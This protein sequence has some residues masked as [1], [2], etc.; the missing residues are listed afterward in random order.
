MWDWLALE[1]FSYNKLRAFT[2]ADSYFLY[3][4]LAI[5]LFFWLRNALHGR[6]FQRLGLT[7]I[8][9]DTASSWF[10]WLR[11]LHPLAGFLALASLLI[12]L[13][14]PQI[15]S[16]LSERDAEVIN[17]MLALDI[18]DSMT[19]KDLLPS[20]LDAAKNVA[21]N[22]ISGRLR[23]RIGLVVFGGDAFTQCPL[24]NDYELLYGFLETIHH[25]QIRTAGTAI[26]N[27]LA[28]CI[29][30]LRDIPAK[31]KVII[32]LSDGEN[33]TGNLD[34]LIAAK[35][36]KAFDIRVYTIALG[37]SFRPD[38]LSD[39]LRTLTSRSTDEGSLQK[40]S[41]LTSGQFY[42][43]TDNNALTGIFQQ[44]DRMERVKVKVRQ[45]KE[46]K[47]YYRVYLNW[48]VVFLL[49]MMLLKVLFIANPLED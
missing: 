44:I 11:F 38:M 35:L 16:A 29:N 46:V 32:L 49:V 25:G 9:A 5:P 6:S 23:D 20:R 27:A 14:R 17:I 1:W 7:F 24:T 3:G 34:P 47:D 26:G 2:W 22:F 31:S 28:V 19:E 48:A 43:A 37:R 13:A 36:A 30:R 41:T 4:I 21:K 40:I 8:H 18:S 33:T 12:A 15:I 39:T 45:Y 42:R 10:V